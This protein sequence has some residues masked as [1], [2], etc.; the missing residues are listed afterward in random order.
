MTDEE[1]DQA[2]TILHRLAGSGRLANPDRRAGAIFA[3]FCAEWFRRESNS[4]FLR[5]DNLAPDLFPAV[6]YSSK[7]QLTLFGLEYW[8]RELRR[9]ANA[10]EFLLTLA[11]E[12]GFPV[13][14]LAEG[15]RSWLKDYLCSIMRRAIS[16]R[17]E[18]GDELLA[19]A[20]EERGRMRKSYQHDDFVALCSELVESLLDLRRKAEAE[21]TGGVRNST[22]LDAKHPGW[23]DELPIYVPAEDAALVT[24]LLTGLLDEKMTGLSSVGV[25]ARRFLVKRSGEWIP[26]VQLLADGEVPASK[27]PGLSAQGRVRAV[28]TG[29]LANHLTGDLALLEA[30]VGEQRHWRVRPFMRI[31]K[32]LTEFRF[33]SPVTTTLTS[34]DGVPLPWTWPRGEALRS[35][36]LVFQQDEGST[37]TEPLLRFLRSGSVSSPAKTLYALVPD[38]WI[39]EPSTEDAIVEV[40]NLSGL[41]RKLVRLAG[42]SYFRSSETDSARFRVE[43]D[44]EGREREL[45]LGSVLDAGFVL[46]D[47][48]WELVG[49]PIRPSIRETGKQ[50]SRI[51]GVNEL[52]VRRPGGRWTQFSGL[53]GGAGLTELSWR[54]P[55]GDV[56]LERRLL[57][58]VPSGARVCGTMR[59]A[60]TGEIRLEGL[61]GWSASVRGRS[62]SVDKAD[63]S[64]LSIRFTG[65][66]IYRLPMTLHP[67][68]GHSFDVIVPLVG[69]DAVIALA[70]GSILAPGAQLDV[71]ALRGAV[72]V[73]PRRTVAHL[74]AK[75]SRSGGL[76][77][78][79]DGELPLGILRSAIDETLATLSGQDDLVELDFIGDTRRPI[80]INRY[81]YDQLTVEFGAVAWSAPT[82]S[83]SAAPVVRMILDPRHEHALEP[84][85]EGRWQIPELCKGPCLVYL[86][87]GVDV[88]SRPVPVML[89]GAPIGYAGDLVSALIIP[90]YMARLHEIEK[91]FSR[92]ESGEDHTEDISWLLD[93][94]I[95]LNGLPATAFDALKLL[96][97]SPL[98]LLRLLFSARD[99][100]ERG[101]IWS[102]QNELPFLWLALPLSAWENALKIDYAVVASALKAFFGEEK[103][104]GEALAR[105]V[106]LRDELVALEPALEAI[107]NLAGLSV[108]QLSTIPSLRD[109]TS[110]YIASQYDRGGEA[111]NDLE[112]RLASAGLKLPSEIE[113]KSHKDFAGLF[114]PV[115]L[116]ASARERLVLERDQALLARRALREDPLYV[117]ASWCHLLKFYA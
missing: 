64:V 46:A 21:N 49:V 50:Q 38:D 81:R 47:E 78:V 107:F 57:A 105:L 76:K 34:L 39:V 73:S 8:D 109:L 80:R 52:F 91:A 7:Q 10:R 9:S 93:A 12:G 37:P 11:L 71:G 90:G 79:V 68:T 84:N 24:E 103:A 13:R 104:A 35:D 110:G 4:T 56:Q 89:P 116:A 94:A 59:D 58:L 3:S 51:P 17:V 31:A 2:K 41:G 92:L 45:E 75:G 114:A 88:V 42:A 48:Q 69:R 30:P 16:W 100:G 54:D 62:C 32:L 43:P 66:P 98:A 85:A 102:L 113:T 101:A 115:L 53:L 95:N 26:A 99:A 70:D 96:P 40:E 18:S 23:R 77:V 33:A 25:E 67:P 20:E 27:L 106:N 44:A 74:A 55:V 60:L 15:A 22:V 1:Y 6:P 117:S 14:I 97:S 83:F 63:G 72:A 87:D 61:P 29:E 108:T 28:P 111:P 86:R 36:V 5:W 65:R 19:I 112:A 82:D